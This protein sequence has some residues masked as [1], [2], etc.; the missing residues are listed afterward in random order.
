MQC[1]C[2]P[3]ADVIEEEG[4]RVQVVVQ[5]CVVIEAAVP[6]QLHRLPQQGLQPPR[7]QHHRGRQVSCK[8]TQTGGKEEGVDD[9]FDLCR[10]ALCSCALA[11]RLFRAAVQIHL[12]TL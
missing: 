2:Q 3:A 10:S 8:D 9:K 5:L 12:L 6:L 7:G 1:S 4:D 11:A